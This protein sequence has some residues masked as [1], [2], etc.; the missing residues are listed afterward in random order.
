M[1]SLQGE[2]ARF[3]GAYL[4]SRHIRMPGASAWWGSAPSPVRGERSQCVVSVLSRRRIV[5]GVRGAG[6]VWLD[7]SGNLW[8]LDSVVWTR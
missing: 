3:L 4:C 5:K 7:Q 6:D 8:G 1:P 2:L